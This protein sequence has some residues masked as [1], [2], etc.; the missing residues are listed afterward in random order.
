M[1]KKVKWSIADVTALVIV[2]ID[3]LGAMKRDNKSI[4]VRIEPIE[5]HNLITSITTND[6]I[7]PQTKMD[8]S[9]DMSGK[10][11]QLSMKEN[12]I[13][14][15]EQFLLQI[16]QKQTTTMISHTKTSM[17]TTH[18][19]ATQTKTNLIQSERSLERTAAL[20]KANAQLISAEQM[21]VLRTSVDVNKALMEASGHSVEQT[22]AALRDAHSTMSKTT[23]YAPMANHVTRLIIEQNETAVPDTFNKDAT[24]LLTISDISILE[25]KVKM[26]ETD[27]ARISIDNSTIVQIDAF[28]DTTFVD[29]ISKISNSSVHDAT[30]QQNANQAV[31]YEV[32]IQ[33]VNAPSETHPDFS[34]TTKVITDTHK[35]MLSIPII[36]LTIRENEN[37]TKGDTA[38]GLDRPQP[39]KDIE[40]KNV[41]NVFVINTNN[42]MTFRPVKVGIAGEKHFEV[43][44]GLKKDEKIVTGTYQ[45]IRELKDG[46]LVQTTKTPDTNTKTKQV[47]KS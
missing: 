27:I 3:G 46:T 33:L 42:K 23:I 14:S 43:L 2:L 4:E 47:A 38:V 30:M 10:I 35:H 19:Q 22:A 11:T 9:S 24:T 28:P 5:Q 34:A 26:D 32:T 45:A 6:Q 20:Q 1:S 31:D 36:A 39:T 13:I 41:E 44:T 12:Q 25:T 15:K 16:D 18:T 29:H 37:L 40:K 8:I 17:T 7:H 21:E